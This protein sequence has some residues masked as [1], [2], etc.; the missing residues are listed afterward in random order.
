MTTTRVHAHTT[1]HRDDVVAVLTD[2]GPDRPDTWPGNDAGVYE[3][4]GSGPG[5]AEVTEGSKRPG[6][7]WQRCRYDWST[8]GV[9]R[10]DVVDSN[11]F[12]A[13]SSWRYDIADEA[14]GAD[15][16]LTVS[17]HPSTVRGRVLDPFLAVGGRW[18]FGADLRRTLRRLE[19]P[20]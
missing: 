10:L 12:G 14:D 8:P 11:A 7:V 3:V 17:R 18:V 20:G 9:V 16:T 19:R 1:L 6:G 4:H 15:V 13:G 5:W 2:F